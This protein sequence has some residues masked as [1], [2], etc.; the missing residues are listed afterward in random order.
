MAFKSKVNLLKG[1]TST[2]EPN[3]ADEMV[4]MCLRKSGP[5]LD[6]Y[7][8]FIHTDRI[9][10]P[11]VLAAW[12]TDEAR[13][14]FHRR[15]DAACSRDGSALLSD[16]DMACMQASVELLSRYFISTPEDGQ[17]LYRI[18]DHDNRIVELCPPTKLPQQISQA[19][20]WELSRL[21][22]AA[23]GRLADRL[24]DFY[25]HNT[26]L[27]QPP[28][29]WAQPHDDCYCLGRAIIQ[30]DPTVLW[31][32]FATFVERLN[33]PRAFAAWFFGIYSGRYR[34]RQMLYISD[35]TGEGGKSTAFGTLE[36]LFNMVVDP[37][38][39]QPIK[40]LGSPITASLNPNIVKN[41]THASSHFKGKKFVWIGDNKNAS[42]LMSQVAKEL[43][44]DDMAMLNPKHLAPSSA[45]LDAFLAVLSNTPPNISSERHNQTRTLWLILSP[46]TVPED[47]VSRNFAKQYQSEMPGFLAYG[48]EC[49]NELCSKDTKIRVNAVVQAATA[50]RVADF[51]AS[52]SLPFEASFVLDPEGRV[53]M[54]ELDGL[55]REQRWDEYRIND[56][57]HWIERTLGLHKIRS[58]RGWYYQGIRMKSRGGWRDSGSGGS[59]SNQ[60]QGDDLMD[61]AAEVVGDGFKLNGY[62]GPTK[63]F[64]SSVL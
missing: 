62:T 12:S 52:F 30:P 63:S 18:V 55:A 59:Y 61:D 31:P 37:I 41:S 33:D 43:S 57:K 53:T 24:L 40:R 19:I 22:I 42:I 13:N 54:A 60:S 1:L 20:K 23:S 29:L 3:I 47:Q 35:Q 6:V 15:F 10:I 34:G 8:E 7:E 58:G 16:N 17:A 5:P 39:G 28:K 50:L 48:E 14:Y 4:K 64:R 9:A 56:F 49:Y 21:H 32:H 38:T 27:V 51:E 44:G 46:L 45:Y 25:S 36:G 11:A 2:F 26:D